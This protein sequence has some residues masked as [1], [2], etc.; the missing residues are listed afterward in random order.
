MR[1]F[2]LSTLISL[3]LFS[4][5][6][7]EK[8]PHDAK[9]YFS[10]ENGKMLASCFTIG[11]VIA[12]SPM[13]QYLYDFYQNNIRNDHTDFLVDHW[14]TMGQNGAIAAYS[15]IALFSLGARGTKAGDF[16]YE[17]LFKSGRAFAIGTIP[18]HTMKQLTGGSRPIYTKRSSYWKPFTLR[19]GVSGDTYTGAILFITLAK[20]VESNYLKALFYGI[21]TLN[22]IGRINDGYHYPSQVFLGWMMAYAACDAVDHTDSKFNLSIG[23][24]RV[25]FGFEF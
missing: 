21:S 10:A 4:L 8:I 25:A 3:P 22:G 13:D 2:L 1:K 20:M 16:A 6:P 7:I 5:S 12:N 19:H 11:A 9:A 18:L 17:L 23:A 15:A 14:R 24:D